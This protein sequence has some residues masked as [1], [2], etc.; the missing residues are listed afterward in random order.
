[1]LHCGSLLALPF[2]AGEVVSRDGRNAL[3]NNNNNKTEGATSLEDSRV[4]FHSGTIVLTTYTSINTRQQ[5][6]CACICRAIC[7]P[8]VFFNISI[9]W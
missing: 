8:V 3:D 2:E 9:L 6:L 5:H 7:F 1:M 4:H